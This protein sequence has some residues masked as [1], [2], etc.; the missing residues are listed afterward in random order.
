M[1]LTDARPILIVEDSDEDF[2]TTLWALKKSSVEVSISRCVDGDQA[3]AYLDSCGN[4]A[5]GGP[6]KL[7]A[8]VLLDINLPRTDGRQ[9]LK[10]IKTSEHLKSVPVVIVSTSS[11]PRDVETCYQFG[12]NSYVVKPTSTVKLRELLKGLLEY[13][14]R[15]VLLP[16]EQGTYVSSS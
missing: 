10:H 11:N 8:L 12:A 7:P 3:I 9:V 16:N 5:E 1:S 6:P 14:L 2:E 15:L 4:V 13:W